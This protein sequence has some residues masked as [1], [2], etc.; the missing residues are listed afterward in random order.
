MF[1]CYNY[2]M[3]TK[4]RELHAQAAKLRETEQFID[5]LSLSDQS[6]FAYDADGDELGFSEG[7]A[8]RSI[9]L[10]V[11]ANLHNSKRLLTLAKYEMMAAVDLARQSGKEDALAL[12]LLSLANL[13]QALGEFSEAVITYK[14]AIEAKLPASHD[15]TSVRADFRL[16][17][18][19]CEYLNG[20]KS[21]KDRALK[22]LEELGNSD[23]PDKYSKD[24]WISGGYMKLADALREDEPEAAREYLSKAKE[25]I[26][27]NSD[28]TLRSKQWTQLSE[29]FS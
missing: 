4:G 15:R 2:L 14:E 11:Y 26:D 22:A 6:L 16:H 8:C 29:K 12:P 20:D 19:T 28:L 13:Q 1:P 24:V 3:S 27:A 21:A 23:E 17:L 9:T 25:I 5:S 7:I 18:A 10:R